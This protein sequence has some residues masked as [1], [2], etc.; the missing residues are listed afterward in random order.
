MKIIQ[1]LIMIAAAFIVLY[2]LSSVLLKQDFIQQLEDI[3]S[4]KKETSRTQD[5]QIRFQ[6]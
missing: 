6:K 3:T 5:R 1:G 2:Y 4:G